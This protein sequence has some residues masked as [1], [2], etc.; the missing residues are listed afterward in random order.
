VSFFLVLTFLACPH[1]LDSLLVNPSYKDTTPIHGLYPCYSW[2]L[3]CPPKTWVLRAQSP[4]Q[5]CWEVVEIKRCSPTGGLPVTVGCT[6]EEQWD[7]SPSPP[8]CYFPAT[9]WVAF[10]SCHKSHKATWQSSETSRT[11]SQGNLSSLQGKP[12]RCLSQWEV[13]MRNLISSRVPSHQGLGTQHRILSGHIQLSAST[14][15]SSQVWA[16]AVECWWIYNFW[17]F[18]S[19]ETSVFLLYLENKDFLKL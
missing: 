10:P 16:P 2:D 12:L 11:V 5:C 1:V 8:V 4:L 19:S 18:V 13:A 9:K 15:C 14:G 7:P 3:N 6:W 17:I